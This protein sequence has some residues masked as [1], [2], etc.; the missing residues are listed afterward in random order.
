MDES[1]LNEIF[2][3][4]WP[5]LIQLAERKIAHWH[6]HQVGPE[7]LV[8]TVM[9]TV[10]RRMSEGKFHFDDEESL[11]KQLYVIMLNRLANKIRDAKTLKR[12]GGKNALSLNELAVAAKEVDETHLAELEEVIR[13]VG[14]QLDESG[15]KTLE[16]RLA[17]YDYVEIASEL[18]CSVKSIQRKMAIIKEKF[19]KL[20]PD[21]AQLA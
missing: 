19:A 5:K 8:V 3:R 16:M 17:G 9:R 7:T 18:G 12:G 21:A 2:T 14:D 20:F 4:Q 6:K 11:S 1:D 13:I 15:Q 10:Y